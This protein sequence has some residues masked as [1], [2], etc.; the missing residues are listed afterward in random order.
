MEALDKLRTVCN[1]SN[2]DYELFKDKIPLKTATTGVVEYG[3][4]LYE[5]APTLIIKADET[6]M[7]A[8]IRGDTRIS[9]KK[10]K[11]FL[12]LTRLCLAK[13]EEIYNLT[14][15]KIG[16]VSLINEGLKTLMDKKVLDNEYVYGG[17]G[18]PN[19]TLKIKVIDLI[20]TTNATVVDF[21][22]LKTNQHANG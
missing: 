11:E 9:F 4:N 10:S 14:G 19:H 8:I 21:T 17:C 20:K 6:I 13:P 3:I 16:N 5:A 22:H 18:A 12:K 2:V 15:S 1:H 7:A